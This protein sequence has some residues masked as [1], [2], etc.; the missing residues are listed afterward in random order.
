MNKLNKYPY[1]VG[2]LSQGKP[3]SLKEINEYRRDLSLYDDE[4]NPR[5]FGRYKEYTYN[6]FSINIKYEM[7]TKKHCI[8]SIDYIKNHSLYKY[9]LSYIHTQGFS[10]LPKY[11]KQ[12]VKD[13]KQSKGPV[14]YRAQRA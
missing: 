1:I 11:Q 2:L 10:K 6:V 4:T 14:S 7:R 8:S 12:F 5:A 13:H 9:L 3:L